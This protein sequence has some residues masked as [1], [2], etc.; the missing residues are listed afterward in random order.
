MTYISIIIIRNH[1]CLCSTTINTYVDEY[2]AQVVTGQ[3]DLD[4]SW[5]EYMNKLKNMGVEKLNEVDGA[6]YERWLSGRQ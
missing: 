1:F 4:A 6:A 5:D 2:Q 3:L